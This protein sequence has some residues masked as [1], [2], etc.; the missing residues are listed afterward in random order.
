MVA[1]TQAE[2]SQCRL[3]KLVASMRAERASAKHAREEQQ[4][5]VGGGEQQRVAA[6]SEP[7]RTPT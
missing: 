1:D 6:G 7:P 4:S 5:A 2:H 3:C